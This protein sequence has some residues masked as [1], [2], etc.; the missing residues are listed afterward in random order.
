MRQ[1][2]TYSAIAI[3]TLA[4]SAF[5][6]T[7]TAPAAAQEDNHGGH[8]GAFEHDASHGAAV[9]ADEG[10]VN[11]A[12]FLYEG[13]LLLDYGIAAEMFLA[14]DFMRAFNVYTVSESGAVNISI[15][16]ETQTDFTFENAPTADVVIVPGG[17]L[18]SQAGQD[19]EM[20]G[21]LSSQHEEGATLFSICTGALLL[22]QAGFLD[23]REATTLH[24]GIHMMETVSPTTI[25]REATFVDGGDIVTAAGSGTA[26]EATLALIARLG[27]PEIAE[28]LR[29]RYLDYPHPG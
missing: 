28:D 26:I 20:A 11:V 29:N 2:R 8:S 16:G 23:G 7:G 17:P 15:L 25:V 18:W 21:F 19:P 1:M 6:T 5:V 9:F 24:A 27:S 12:V 4:C 10:R 22:A 14:A 13:A 3:L